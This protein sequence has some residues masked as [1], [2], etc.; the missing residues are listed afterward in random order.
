MRL[1]ILLSSLFISTLSFAEMPKF[2]RMTLIVLEN[3][4]FEKAMQ[5]PFLKSLAAKGALLTNYRGVARPSQPNYI[6][7]TSGDTFGV[8]TDDNVSLDVR[9][10][11]NLLEDAGM[12]WRVYAQ[13]LPETECFT[14]RSHGQYMRKHQP[15]ISYANVRDDEARCA[16]IVPANRIDG[17]VL[18]DKMANFSLYVPD[19]NNNG[20]DTGVA[21]ADR[22][23]Q[24]EFGPRFNSEAFMK[25]MVVAITFDEGG[26]GGQHI[27]TILIGDHVRPGARSDAKLDHFSMLRTIEEGFGLPTLGRR[28]DKASAITDIW[29]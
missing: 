4:D 5:Q 6:A 20:H 7:L 22:W 25:G 26:S 24:K 14:G 1:L 23:L 12:S 9:H 19:D 18:L 27:Y 11:G 13:G 3:A 17:D 15:F 10:L 8:S 29:Q 16:K 28:D 2:K 21:Y